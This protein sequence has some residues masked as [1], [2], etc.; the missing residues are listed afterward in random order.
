MHNIKFLCTALISLTL[1]GCGGGGSAN[2]DTKTTSVDVITGVELN[3]AQAIQNLY[4]YSGTKTIAG[5]RYQY[6]NGTAETIDGKLYS[7]QNVLQIAA[8]GTS[9]SFKRYFTTNPFAIYTVDYSYY[10]RSAYSYVYKIYVTR[11]ISNI[12]RSAKIGDFGTYETAKVKFCDI[13]GAQTCT[14]QPNEVSSWTIDKDT[15]ET[16][17]FCYG[18]STSLNLTLRTCYKMNAQNSIIE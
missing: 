14:D 13:A 15:N 18:S 2:T 10:P 1:A 11:S 17:N 4:T 5:V 9:T 6:S 8:D 16:A 3:P 12:P 7:V